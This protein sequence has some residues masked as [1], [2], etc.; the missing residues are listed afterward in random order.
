[1]SQ[2]TMNGAE[3]WEDPS[4]L[5]LQARGIEDCNAMAMD[6]NELLIYQPM[7]NPGYHFA[8]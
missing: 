6:G 2:P 1:M 8:Y 5:Y 4:L 7:Q 3:F